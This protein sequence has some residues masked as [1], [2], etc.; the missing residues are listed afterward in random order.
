M[1]FDSSYT[2]VVEPSKYEVG[3]EGALMHVYETQLNYNAMMKAVG[4]S[5]LKYYQETGGDLFVNEA[6]AFSG[7]LEK[8]KALFKKIIEKIKA[9]FARFAMMMRK[10][11][12]DDKAFVKKYRSDIMAKSTRVRDFEYEGWRFEKLDAYVKYLGD[13]ASNFKEVVGALNT[14]GTDT[15]SLHADD[16]A[17]NLKSDSERTLSAEGRNNEKFTAKYFNDVDDVDKYI[18]K[19]RGF[20]ADDSGKFY[21]ASD[22]RD[23]VKEKCYGYSKES[24]KP[25]MAKELRYIEET[26]ETVRTAE[27][28]KK[29]IVDNLGKVVQALE[30]VITAANKSDT[31]YYNGTPNASDVDSIKSAITKAASQAIDIAKAESDAVTIAYGIAVGALKDRNRQAKSICVKLMGAKNESAVYGRGYNESYSYSDDIFSGVTIR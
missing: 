17:I 1:I 19:K 21:D 13:N 22:F 23:A 31:K 4:I 9:I 18:E 7:F 2:G 30:K 6:G 20:I 10:Y 28:T 14:I 15:Y 3:L 27:K 24:F 11:T 5:E 26:K 8:A 29:D 25:E 12:M 16:D